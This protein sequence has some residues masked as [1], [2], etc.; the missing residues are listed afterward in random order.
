MRT[1]EEYLEKAGE[2]EK[3]AARAT[4]ASLRKRYADVAACYR[5]LADERKRLIDEG[6]IV[7]K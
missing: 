1:V 2:F 4:Q 5:L 3:L 6:C 7:T